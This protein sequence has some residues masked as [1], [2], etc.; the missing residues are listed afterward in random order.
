MFKLCGSNCSFIP[1][2]E[3]IIH[4]NVIFPSL[5]LNWKTDERYTLEIDKKGFCFS[6]QINFTIF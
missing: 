5:E 4:F 2:T 1:D 3:I 6:L